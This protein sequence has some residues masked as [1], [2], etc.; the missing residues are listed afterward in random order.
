MNQGLRPRGFNPGQQR[1]FMQPALIGIAIVLIGMLIAEFFEGIVAPEH[2]ALLIQFALSGTLYL[3]LYYFFLTPVPRRLEWAQWPNAVITGV[4]L[5]VVTGILEDEFNIFML[6]MLPLAVAIIAISGSRKHAYTTI[7]ITT[8]LNVIGKLTTTFQADKWLVLAS[9]PVFAIFV[10]ETVRRLLEISRNQVERLEIVNDF[11]RQIV[12]TLDT[13]QVL[14]LLNSAILNA[15]EGDTYFVGL[16]EGEVLSIDML[17]DDGEYFPSVR[18]PLEGT[19]SSWVIRN[20]QT[21]FIPDLREEPKLEGVKKVL[22]GKERTN[23]SWMGVPLKT[24]HT[25]GLIVIGAYQPN[26]FTRNDVELLE[27]L[28]QQAAQSLDNTY[29]HAEVEHLSQL[30]S[31]TGVYNHGHFLQLLREQAELAQSTNTSVSLIMMDI[32]YFKQ[33]NDNYG[34]LAG[35]EVLTT[36]CA[37]I[38]KH[39]KHQDFVGRWGGEEFVIALPYTGGAQAVQVAERI[40]ASIAEATIIGQAHE[41]V[42][43]PTVSQGIAVFPLETDE[44]YGLIDLADQ[45]LYVAKERGRNQI[46]PATSYWDNPPD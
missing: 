39:I 32:D 17:Y 26:V 10:V 34:H 38:R 45:R 22:V 14:T 46:E 13:R 5:G 30:D 4:S 31:L 3:A 9:L 25:F 37:V 6:L 42:P 41:K 23:L 15:L 28:A 29:K 36:L 12:S 43:S 11:A 7:A 20:G 33:Y 8:G 18:A 16:V 21:L 44:M 35:D 1:R 24:S 27:N 2:H 19:L 40:R